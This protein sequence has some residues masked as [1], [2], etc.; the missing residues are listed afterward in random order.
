[1]TELE[2]S[3]LDENEVAP[4]PTETSPQARRESHWEDDVVPPSHRNRTL[5]VCFDGTGDKFDAD[6]SFF[7]CAIVSSAGDNGS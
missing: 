3:W 2:T 1:M 4:S 7:Y 5:I 6:V